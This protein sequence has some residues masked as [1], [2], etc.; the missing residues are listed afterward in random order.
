LEGLAKGAG[1]NA[2]FGLESLLFQCH[3]TGRAAGCGVFVEFPQ[4]PPSGFAG[5]G[6]LGMEGSSK[7]TLRIWLIRRAAGARLGPVA[8]KEARKRAESLD[9]TFSLEMIASIEVLLPLLE[10]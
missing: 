2:G 10:E 7:F 6:H 4:F 9:G 8:K 5:Q 3:G 1:R